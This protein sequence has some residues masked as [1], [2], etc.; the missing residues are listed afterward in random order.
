[1]SNRSSFRAKPRAPRRNRGGRGRSNLHA[2]ELPA[3]NPQI[4]MN[5]MRLRYQTNAAVLSTITYPDLLD[6]VLVARTAVAGFQLFDA[7]R[8]REVAIS[9]LG[10]STAGGLQL[11]PVSAAVTFDATAAGVTGDLD[12][13]NVTS[14]GIEPLHLRA[15]PKPGSAAS[16]WQGSTSNIAFTVLAPLNAVIDV[17]VDYKMVDTVNPLPCQNALVGATPGQVYWRG[18]DGLALGATNFVPMGLVNQI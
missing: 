16:L 14:M 13:H 2:N 12:S 17:V 6:A 11:A 9:A 4:V 5:S 18:L 7:V 3:F 1:M 10:T 15:R 8:I